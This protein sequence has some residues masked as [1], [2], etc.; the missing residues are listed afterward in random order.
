M[1]SIRIGIVG[2]GKIAR[3][4]HI[5][6]IG[7]SADFVLT[8]VASPYDRLPGVASFPSLETMLDAQP[9][10]DAVAICTPPQAHYDGARLA[11]RRGLHVLVEKPPC[12]TVAQVE[13]LRAL[14]ASLGRTLFATWHSRYA[15]AVATAAGLLRTRT[16]RRAHVSWKE[17]VR[18]WHPGQAWLR[19]AGGLGVF[20]AA[21]NALS[22]LTRLIPDPI[23][24]RS[25]RLH[26][27]ANWTTPIAAEAEFESA[28]GA[29]ISASLDFRHPGSPQWDIDLGTDEGVLRLTGG[30]AGL[31]VEGHWV[32]DPHPSLSSE[33]AAIYGEFAELIS[34]GESDVDAGPLQCV[35]DI[36]LVAQHVPAAPF[37][38]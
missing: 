6:A 12:S 35:A 36:Q 14:A 24:A 13:H 16:L 4:Q 8:A 1:K 29:I 18:Q 21:I 27:P 17:D 22:I 7:A 38:Y 28:S 2:L 5:P 15:P 33:Y 20:D 19:E 23:F 32:T 37:E 3:D 11:L 31:A 9:E 30:G 26:V 10:L 25:A 34:R